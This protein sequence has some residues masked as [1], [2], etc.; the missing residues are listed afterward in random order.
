MNSNQSFKVDYLA[1]VKGE[2]RLYLIELNTD[3]KSRRDQQDGYLEKAKEAGS[4]TLLKGLGLIYK[5]T[6]AKKKY[7]CLLKQLGEIGLIS[8]E[9]NVQILPRSGACEIEVVYIQP[10]N[11]GDREN[12]IDFFHHC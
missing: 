10:S 8:I 6:N 9:G 11:P 7:R 4:E 5:A 1:K 12:T 2:N 3:Q